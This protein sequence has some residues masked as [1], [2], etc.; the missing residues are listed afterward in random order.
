MTKIF[1]SG[2][3]K[4]GKSYHAQILAKKMQQEQTQQQH[5]PLYYL[6]TMIPC[7]NE[8]LQR[9]R[10]HQ[11]E[12][13]GWGFETFEVSKNILSVPKFCNIN[14]VFLL[15]SVTSLLANEMFTEKDATVETTYEKLSYELVM[16][17]GLLKNIIFVSDFIYSD[18]CFYDTSTEIFRKGLAFIDRKLAGT[19]ETVL[20][21]SCGNII[22]HKSVRQSQ[23]NHNN[24]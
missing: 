9:I 2:G 16:L 13:E 1:I 15:D 24:N 11:R 22:V 8:D 12:R 5:L 14:G 19:C 21:M 4:N 7:D 3:C 20:E 17:T 10:R 18:A 6:A 23:T